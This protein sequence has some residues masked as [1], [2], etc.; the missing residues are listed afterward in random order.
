VTVL[1]PSVEDVLVAGLVKKGYQ[2]GPLCMDKTTTTSCEGCSLVA[3]SVEGVLPKGKKLDCSV[4][5]NQVQRMLRDHSYF[6]VITMGSEGAATWMVG[7]IELPKPVVKIKPEDD[8]A[9]DE[10][11]KL[12]TR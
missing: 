9:D 6:S 2:V 7:N 4:L 1:K 5:L 10:L 3:L 11:L 8:P 12:Q